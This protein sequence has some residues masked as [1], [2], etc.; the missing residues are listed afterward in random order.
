MKKNT[1]CFVI[2]TILIT[3]YLFAQNDFENIT[4]GKYRYVHSDIMEEDRLL[5]IHLPDDYESSNDSYSVVFQLYSHFT[6][7]YY[8]PA[9]RTTDIMGENGQAPKM[10]VVGIKNQEFRYRDLLP[11]DH[12]GV[13][14]EIDN[15][16]KFFETE[17]IPF[18]N[19]NYR[20]NKY[21]ILSAPQAGAAFGVYAM[22]VKPKLFNAFFLTSPFWV[23]SSQ[24]T[25]L[26]KFTDA[27]EQND[28]SNIFIMLSYGKYES[29]K[30]L[31]AIIKF[32]NLM[33]K[34]ESPSFEFY[35]NMLDSDFDFST[36]IDFEA[37]MKQ[38]FKHYLFPGNEKGQDLAA[39]IAYYE[40]LSEQM[41]MPIK[42]PEHALVFE[43]DKFVQENKLDKALCIFKK[44]HELYPEGLMGYDRIGEVYLKKEMYNESLKY[45]LM[46]LEKQPENPRILNKVTAIRGEINKKK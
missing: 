11:E 17:L 23:E 41:D 38:L 14:S 20:V 36:P 3:N 10:I 19:E 8:L 46:F 25:L 43:G 31:D 1:L 42:I 32:K 13:K 9:I 16:L 7:N 27:V 21:R 4:Y 44:M 39:I 6:Y 22:S 26:S 30:E 2:F 35:D 28:Y 33:N 24:E 37:G 40:N 45:Y 29:G 15:F 18:I 12:W 5:Y 34:I